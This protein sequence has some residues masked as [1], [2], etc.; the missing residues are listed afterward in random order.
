MFWA[1]WTGQ[2][3]V[4]DVYCDVIKASIGEPGRV[5][6]GDSGYVGAGGSIIGRVLA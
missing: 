5:L 6:A 2:G 1:D 3:P 4:G